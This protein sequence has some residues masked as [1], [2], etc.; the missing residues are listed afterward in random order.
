ML[1]GEERKAKILEFVV[2]NSR[3]SVQE[4]CLAFD[5]SE[6]TIRRDLKELEEAK[7][8]KRTHGGA[9]SLQGVNFEPTYLDK[10][11]KLQNE[12]KAIAKKAAEFIEEGDTILLD[13]GTTTHSL[14][15]WL[16]TYSRLTVVTNSL[17]IAQEL[18]DARGIDLLV[19]GGTLRR[20]TLA[21]VGPMADQV[22]D[23]IRVD[24]AFVATNGV[25]IVEGLTTPNLMEAAT[26]RKLIRAAK[27]VFLLTD[28]SKV[29]K[30]SLA[31]FAE[32]T[33][34]S[35]CIMDDAVSP[36]FVAEMEARGID[37]YLAATLAAK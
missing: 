31:R 5:V 34:I 15:D 17:T 6:A 25:D 10:E 23:T 7:M 21:M 3:A 1:Y 37:V 35:K 28:H 13:S 16:K 4:L 30:V 11:I 8:L 2:K 26:K 27:Q 36:A 32:I 22:L 33:D 18:H 20:E 14:V 19:V 29:G 24:K 9:I 12:K